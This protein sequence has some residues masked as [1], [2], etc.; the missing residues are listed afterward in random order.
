MRGTLIIFLVLVLGPMSGCSD[1]DY[2]LQAID[3]QMEVLRESRDIHEIMDDPAVGSDLKSQ[4]DQ[5]LH[6]RM[7][8]SSHLHLP[9]N[10]SYRSYADLGRPYIVW[11]VVATPEFSLQPLTW[12]FPIAGCVPYRGYFKKQAAEAFA[13]ELR[14][15][16][17]DVL[18]YGVQAYS[19]L[20][21]FDDPLLNT[22]NDLPESYL[23]GIIFHELA[24]QK[25]YLEGD[26]DFNEAFA[27]TVEME[28]VQRWL[29]IHGKYD[30]AKSYRARLLMEQEFL[31]LARSYQSRLKTL[32][33][34]GLPE[35]RMREAKAR[36]ISGFQ[37]RVR[38]FRDQRNKGLGFAGWLDP[39]LNNARFASL[40]TYY[41]LVP[42]FQ[43]LL[44]LYDG[45][46]KQFYRQ[47]AEIASRPDEE[48]V[49]ILAYLVK[50]QPH[51][52]ARR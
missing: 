10:G 51:T 48:R 50:R 39:A 47:V 4:L 35:A 16:D 28:G 2:Y 32:Y 37:D 3:G 8:A 22:F 23:A 29:E 14:E 49:R 11:N 43:H 25:I 19:T 12:C 15:A 7:F 17:R 41:D 42:A 13:R 24:H 38:H 36:L 26:S 31:E 46:L 34:S 52:S 5:A 18:V 9:D 1:L 20:N 40:N 45:D 6:I 27:K 21:W 44:A 30:Q 33:A